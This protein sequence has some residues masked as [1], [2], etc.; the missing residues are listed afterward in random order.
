MKVY[1][2]SEMQSSIEKSGVGRAIYH[3]KN[4]LGRVGIELADNFEEADVVHINTVLP[5][6]Y[7]MAKKLRRL[8]IPL[9]YHAHSTREDF[10]NSYIGA[11]LV[12]GIFKRWIIGCYTQG[13]VIVTPSEYSRALLRSYGI[14]NEIFV[15]SNGIDLEDYQRN[16]QAGKEFRRKYGF[17]DSDKVVVSAGLIM[18][19]KGVHDFAE[20][21]RRCPEYKFIW[22]GDSNLNLAGKEVRH[23]VKTAPPNLTFAGYVPKES[24][25]AALSG[26]DLFLFPSYEE[27]EGIIV[28]EALAMKIPVL[29]RDI[30]VYGDW[31]EVGKNAY[32]AKDNDGFERRLRDILEGRAPDLTEKGYETAVNKSIENTG[33]KLV[34][35]YRRAIALSQKSESVKSL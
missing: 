2:Y 30:P 21:A 24:I 12:S 8:G 31:I 18:K 15:I 7:R 14:K 19:R 13:N 33:K 26:S 5:N 3:Q 16:E 27:T 29:L 23:A 22:F 6:S 34:E 28:L 4:A 9:V 25:K 35:A 10:R 32:T 1:I 17:S 20:L 11:N